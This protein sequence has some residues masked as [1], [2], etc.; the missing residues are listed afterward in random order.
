MSGLNAPSNPYYINTMKLLRILVFLLTFSLSQEVGDECTLYNGEIGFLE[1][2]L[3]CYPIALLENIGDGTCDDGIDCCE[4]NCPEFA[5]DGGDCIG[6][7]YESDCELFEECS[8]GDLNNDNEI[9]IQDVLIIV[10]CILEYNCDECS[11]LNEDS[12]TN[13]IDILILVDIILNPEEPVTDYDGNVYQ[14]VQIE[15][16]FWMAENLKVTH[17]RNGDAIQYVQSESSEPDVWENLST[18]A[19]GYYNDDLSH[20]ETYGNLYNWYA[21]DDSRGVCPD[22]WHV[23]TDDEY[24]ALEMYLGMSQSEA[25]DTGWRGTN[26]GSKLAGN[27]SLWNSGSLES[28]AEFGT[29]GFAGLP[30]GYRVFNNGYYYNIGYFGYFWSSSEYSSSHAWY[31]GLGYYSTS[32]YRYGGSRR[33]GFSVRCVR[34]VE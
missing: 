17:Y 1:C 18:G 26:E 32:V 9:N 10:N 15:D 20:Q 2:N 11:D 13:V 8:D 34:P 3:A 27:A 5:C 12:T 31:R 7:Y 22:G 30:S 21:V 6:T 19:Y 29:S 24:K 23:P 25:D 28:N 14:T 16:Q 4:L 33:Y